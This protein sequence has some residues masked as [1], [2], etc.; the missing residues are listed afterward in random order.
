MWKGKPVIGGDVGGIRLQVV[1][2]HTGFLVNTPEGAAHRIRYLL[3]HRDSM[4]RMGTTAR[5]FVRENFLLTRHIR[6]YL[7]L[8][9]VTFAHARERDRGVI[10]GIVFRRP[11]RGRYRPPQ[12]K[13]E[14]AVQPK[15]YSPVTTGEPVE[16]VHGSPRR[17]SSDR[18]KSTG[19][20]VEIAVVEDPG[21]GDGEERPAHESFH[22]AGIEA[23]RER[24][25]IPFVVSRPQQPRTKTPQRHVR[26]RMEVVETRP[27]HF[28]NMSC[29][30]FLSAESCGIVETPRPGWRRG[31]VPARSHPL[32]T[33]RCS[34]SQHGDRGTRRSR[35][36]LGIGLGRI[37]RGEGGDEDDSMGDAKSEKRLHEAPLTAER[38]VRSNKR[39]ASGASPSMRKGRSGTSSGAPPVTS[40]VRN[41][42]AGRTRRLP[43]SS[44]GT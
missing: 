38:F 33:P 43:P 3:H 42:T 8:M 7:T 26:E 1:N 22:R 25:Q 24:F 16:G 23:F 32:H 14:P 41:G 29:R 17:G 2:H 6:E 40:R 10:R 4:D 15:Q 20:Q 11:L 5:E 13:P 31:R 37:R 12:V 27:P 39:G 35:A 18:R 44:R 19:G 9:L 36:A 34:T 28:R 21:P 30:N